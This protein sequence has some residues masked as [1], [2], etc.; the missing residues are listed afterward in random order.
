MNGSEFLL[1][2]LAG[3]LLAFV[4]SRYGRDR[5]MQSLIDSLK[6]LAAANTILVECNLSLQCE[7]D[8]LR[9]LLEDKTENLDDE[10]ESWKYGGQD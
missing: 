6:E 10:G 9:D 7:A 3:A 2:G 8:N 4:A 5:S 1:G